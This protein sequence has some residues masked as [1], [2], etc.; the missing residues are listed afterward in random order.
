MLTIACV[1]SMTWTTE[2]KTPVVDGIV[3]SANA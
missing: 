2:P 1:E 3:A